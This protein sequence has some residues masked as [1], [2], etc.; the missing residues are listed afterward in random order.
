MSLDDELFGDWRYRWSRLAIING[1]WHVDNKATGL[2]H[3][4]P[5][6]WW[7]PRDLVRFPLHY[8]WCRG[9]WGTG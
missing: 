6:R 3:W 4:R 9:Y 2:S 8:W 1:R 7:S 5:V